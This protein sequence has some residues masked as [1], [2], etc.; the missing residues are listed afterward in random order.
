MILG[1]KTGHETGRQKGVGKANRWAGLLVNYLARQESA[2]E[3]L[4]PP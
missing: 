4:A 1:L 2:I 3:D